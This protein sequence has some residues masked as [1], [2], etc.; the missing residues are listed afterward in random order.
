MQAA[1]L[2]EARIGESKAKRRRLKN[3]L[4]ARVCSN[5]KREKCSELSGTN[6]KL[7]M[8]VK[9]LE[10]DNRKLR[11]EVESITG[12]N[13]QLSKAAAD[14]SQETLQLRAHVQH[15]SQLLAQA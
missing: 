5:K 1:N 15:L 2:T 12:L 9:D 11:K 7:T 8:R 14:A 10:R 13:H 3:R 4:S 6:T